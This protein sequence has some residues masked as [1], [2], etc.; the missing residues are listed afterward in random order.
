MRQ[1]GLDAQ[2]GALVPA[3]YRTGSVQEVR[4]SLIVGKRDLRPIF[5]QIQQKATLLALFDTC[6]SQD[7]ARDLLS[8]PDP[9]Y[10][11]LQNLAKSPS[12]A[13]E[14][15]KDERNDVASMVEEPFPYRNAISMAAASRNQQ[16]HDISARQIEFKPGLTLDGQPHGVF[17]NGL[18]KGLEGAADKNGDGVITHQELF[19]YLQEQSV[20]WEQNP[21]IEYSKDN[22][23]LLETPIFGGVKSAPR[24]RYEENRKTRVELQRIEPALRERISALPGIVV[25][26]QEGDLQVRKGKAG[27]YVLS[28]GNGRVIYRRDLSPDEL[29]ARIAAEPSIRRLIG[30]SFPN[31]NND[32]LLTARKKEGASGD[33]VFVAG[34]ILQF[35]V[36]ASRPAYLLLADID[37]TGT[38]T[39]VYPGTGD[40]VSAV[41][42]RTP[43]LLGPGGAVL[44]PFGLEF[45]KL[46]AFDEKPAW[47]DSLRANSQERVR[48]FQPGTAEFERFLATLG[49]QTHASETRLRI[50]TLER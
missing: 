50:I 47:Y 43:K 28:Q 24:S 3:D 22:A 13:D 8:H 7:A 20:A 9:K 18:L 17:T 12:D 19:S 39:I 46:F 25:T 41:D 33:A 4:D 2:T 29:L 45:L 40:P 16:A 48:M 23:A 30:L 10:V 37:V 21:Q 34:Q 15:A 32:L 31:S 26:E 44:E 36:R 11:P 38:V 27:G 5:T 14:F 6:Y 49:A 1:Y 35:E 42:A